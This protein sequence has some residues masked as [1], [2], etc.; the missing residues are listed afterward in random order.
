M[1]ICSTWSDS[2]G[3][4]TLPD[5]C[6]YEV[7]PGEWL[8]VRNRQPEKARKHRPR[9]LALLFAFVLGGSHATN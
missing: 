2:R 8:V 1:A 7:A 6:R 3:A 9:W 5:P 4:F